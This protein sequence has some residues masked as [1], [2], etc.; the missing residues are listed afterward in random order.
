MKLYKLTFYILIPFLFMGCGEDESVADDETG[1][2]FQGRDCL[3]CHNVDLGVDKNLV[4]GGSVFKSAGVT[5]FEDIENACDADL[6]IE[7]IN[8]DYSVAYSSA[9]YYDGDSKGYKG[10]GN[11]FLLDRL[12]N[13]SLN[14]GYKIRIVDRLT[15]VSVA[16]S[17]T[18]H[19]FSG[20]EFDID[21]ADDTNNRI[22]CNACHGVSTAPMY[23]Q[24]NET[25]CK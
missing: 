6:A 14:G 20:A 11:V 19:D 18:I 5:D 3:A 8:E 9:D 25:L 4:L 23:V 10:R 12:F 1:W 16:Q 17:S 15:G 24:Y 7:F 2:H 13:S 22:S 21:N